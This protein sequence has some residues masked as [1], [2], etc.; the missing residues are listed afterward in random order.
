MKKIQA[1]ETSKTSPVDSLHAL[2]YT[3]PIQSNKVLQSHCCVR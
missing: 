2:K 3:S 1:T